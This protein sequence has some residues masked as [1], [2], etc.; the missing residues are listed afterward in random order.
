MSPGFQVLGVDRIIMPTI[1]FSKR[2]LGK[3]LILIIIPIQHIRRERHVDGLAEFPQDPFRIIEQVVSVDDTDFHTG[4][5]L[6]VGAGAGFRVRTVAD[7]GPRETSVF[8][9]VEEFL[10]LVVAGFAGVELVEPGAFDEGWDAAAV[11]AGDGPVGVAD[12]EGEVEALEDLTW[13]NGGV[14]RLRTGFVGERRALRG[15]VQIDSA[16]LGAVDAVETFETEAALLVELGF[17]TDAALDVHERRG[18]T[19]G[20]VFGRDEVVGHVLDE[21]PLALRNG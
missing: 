15:R 6:A 14:L 18:D 10:Q 19:W 7:F 20:L 8:A 2:L 9:V 12:E 11:V 1:P 17:G 21:D 16:V 13:H 3:L 5:F 4:G